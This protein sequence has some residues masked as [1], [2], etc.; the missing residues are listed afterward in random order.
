LWPTQLDNASSSSLQLR[1]QFK[2]VNSAVF[3]S[4]HALRDVHHTTQ[5]LKLCRIKEIVGPVHQPLLFILGE[6]LLAIA[7]NSKD[8]I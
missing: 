7:P 3:F 4:S 2:D 1:L 8:E 5:S 6:P